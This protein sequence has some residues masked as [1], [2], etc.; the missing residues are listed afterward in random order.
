MPGR[1]E[2]SLVRVR[3]GTPAEFEEQLAKRLQAVAPDWSFEV[4]PLAQLRAYVVPL[5]LTPLIVGGIV[6]VFLLLMVGLG[7]IGVLW[8]NL[9]QRTREIGLRRAAGA[10]RVGASIRRCCWSRWC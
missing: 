6:A 3:P 5:R 2:R 4:Q 10:S 8:Q 1:P 9:L 7:L